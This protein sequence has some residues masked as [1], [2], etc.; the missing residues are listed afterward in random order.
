M[1]NVLFHSP[2]GGFIRGF[3]CPS[4]HQGQYGSIKVNHSQFKSIEMLVHPSIS[5][6]VSGLVD[7]LIGPSIGVIDDEKAL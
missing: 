1:E 4:L 2:Q 7:R 5:W 3:F 6:L